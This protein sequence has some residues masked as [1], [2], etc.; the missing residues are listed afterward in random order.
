MLQRDGDSEGQLQSS[1]RRVKYVKVVTPFTVDKI[2]S[3]GK[4]GEI[5]KGSAFSATGT[6][7]RFDAGGGD[8]VKVKWTEATEK[9]LA[10]TPKATTPTKMDFDFPDGLLEV[11]LDT[12]LTFE[13]T[14]GGADA[15]TKGAKLV[16]A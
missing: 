16:G 9:E 15:Q 7:L 3:E 1:F 11:P 13:F 4:D 12:E 6:N 10:L 5:V 8:S 2:G 14:L